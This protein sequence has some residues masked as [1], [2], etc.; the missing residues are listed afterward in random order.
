[1][2]EETDLALKRY[3]T[4]LRYLIY[5]H[6]MYWTRSQFFLVAEAALLGFA[7]TTLPKSQ[8]SI[9]IMQ[10]VPIGL[11]SILGVLLTILWSRSLTVTNH[12]IMSWEEICVGLEPEAFG[13]LKVF[14]DARPTKPGW[15][16]WQSSKAMARHSLLLFLASWV[17]LLGYAFFLLLGRCSLSN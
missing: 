17:A 10:L 13:G 7:L 3:D 5:E 11:A 9:S 16:Q 8:R 4:I 12:W 2:S 1:M 15:F 14:K 6:T